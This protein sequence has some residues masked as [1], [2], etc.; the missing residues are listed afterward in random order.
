MMCCVLFMLTSTADATE[1]QHNFFRPVHDAGAIFRAQ[2][3]DPA[4]PLPADAGGSTVTPSE[5]GAAGI[6]ES[7]TVQEFGLPTIPGTSTWNAFSPPM[8][9]DPF[10][11]A[12]GFNY[13]MQ[14]APYGA[15]PF[16]MAPNPMM[17]GYGTAPGYAGAPAQGFQSFGANGPQPFRFGHTSRLDV[18]WMPDSQV[19]S[20]AGGP[21]GDFGE[22]GVDFDLAYA[23]PFMP[24]WI[25]TTTKEFRLRNWSGPVGT[26]GLPGSAFRFGLDFALETPKQGPFSI[27]LAL[28]P[29]INSDLDASPTSDMWQLDGRG[30]MVFQ[31]DQFWTMAVGAQFWDR[32]ND[33]VLPYGGFVYRDDFW[34]WRLMFPEARISLFLGNEPYWSKWMYVR[35]EY[36]IEAYEISTAIPGSDEVELEDWRVALGF[37]M[38]AGAYRWFVEGGWVFNRDVTY[39]RNTASNFSPDTGFIGRVGIR[40]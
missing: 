1:P 20:G 16:G 15:A 4:V 33:Q 36:H 7:G 13:G 28:N 6:G 27:E 14:Q 31:L 34:E 5:S 38:D 22:F 21:V 40:Y 2:S 25:L 35:A 30:A 29:S 39:K 23:A 3:A 18:I 26:A 37:Q 9:P 19:D 11:P 24:G 12:Q 8:T 10:A 32:V 17:P